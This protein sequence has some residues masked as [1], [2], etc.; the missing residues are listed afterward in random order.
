MRDRSRVKAYLSALE[1]RP[2]LTVEFAALLA[3]E[4]VQQIYPGEHE[5]NF[6]KEAMKSS[7]RRVRAGLKHPGRYHLAPRGMQ[8]T[9]EQAW[10]AFIALIEARVSA[11][12]KK[13]SKRPSQT[14]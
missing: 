3:R 1:L 7:V 9:V 13:V 11:K 12:R 6:G 14:P 5:H 2:D 4:R 10:D 8:Q